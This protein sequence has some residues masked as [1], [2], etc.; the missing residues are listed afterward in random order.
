MSF[1]VAI[2]GITSNLAQF[3]V[4]E[5]L[6]RHTNIHI[7]GSS[8]NPSKLS[9]A[10]KDSR[11][12]LF[13]SEPF[14]ASSL[15]TL[16]HGADV[17]IC[18]YFAD[19]HTMVEGQKLLIDLCEDEGVP[20]Y[21][22]SDYTVDFRGLNFGDTP[23]KDPM[24]HVQ[25]YLETRKVVKG[26][27]ILVGMFMETFWT[28]FGMLDVEAKRFSYWGDGTE[29]W[30]MTSIRGVAAYVSA[31]ASDAQAVG[32]FKFCGDSKSMLGIAHELEIVYGSKLTLENYEAI[33]T[34][35]PMQRMLENIG[36]G[37]ELDNGKYPDVKSET[38]R[39]FL[40][41]RTMTQLVKG[42]NNVQ[43]QINLALA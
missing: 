2:A 39:E 1:K 40:E 15:R 7:S 16:I 22:A 38:I 36:L 37:S 41:A 24:K 33:G 30:E 11:I 6:S 10:F 42:D 14:D 32:F 21:I 26:V 5:L 8:R 19:N 13:K 35:T 43:A 17:V 29:V 20:R 27:H 4:T 18:C 25:A 34:I 12:T 23:I 3:I 31:V 9:P 28:A